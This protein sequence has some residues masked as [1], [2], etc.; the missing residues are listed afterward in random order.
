[1]NI[2]RYRGITTA[3]ELLEIEPEQV[4]YFRGA[5]TYTVAEVIAWQR[6][7]GKD[8]KAVS[9]KDADYIN[10]NDVLQIIKDAG[11]Y[12]LVADKIEALNTVKVK[13]KN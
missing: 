7:M 3:E 13:E 8:V 9:I 11:V 12:S 6:L 2:L 4:Y 1:M 5:G 10:K